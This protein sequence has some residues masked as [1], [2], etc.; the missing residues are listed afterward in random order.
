MICHMYVDDMYVDDKKMICGWYILGG[1]AQPQEEEYM[2][3]G[4][5]VR[6]CSTR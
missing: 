5:W 1:F 3:Y 2:K 4:H 6:S